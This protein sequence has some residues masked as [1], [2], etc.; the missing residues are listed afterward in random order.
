MNPAPLLAL[1]GVSVRYGAVQALS[2]V[3][4]AVPE[5]GFV[6]LIGPNGAGKTTLFN[7]VSGF[8]RPRTGSVVLDGRTVTRRSPQARARLGLVR[9]FQNV[10]LD[11]RATVDE[12][13]RA[14]L[15]TGRAATELRDL[16][17]PLDGR[18]EHR[19][20]I[21]DVLVTF[22]LARHRH[23]VV[24]DLSTGVAKMVELAC[25]FLR[26]P[27][28]L[29]L[30]E[31]SSGLSPDET[32]NLAGAL[33]RLHAERGLSVLM[34]EHDMSLVTRTASYIYC[35]DFGSVIGE[36]TPVEVRNDASVIDAYLGQAVP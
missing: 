4:V 15:T 1:A 26:R 9:T 5:G 35:L 8:T 21:D 30:D 24:R 2:D 18:A 29:L 28:L 19:A 13:L 31:P 33:S 27:R 10:G 32:D 34:I 22:D 17:A 7:V 36:G 23:T 14:G 11:K 16:V 6:G 20:A 25:A 12:N 3:S